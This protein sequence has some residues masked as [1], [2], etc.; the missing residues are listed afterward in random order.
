MSDCS[1]VGTSGNT[2]YRDDND[3]IR[4]DKESGLTLS[5]SDC[6]TVGTSGNT[7]YRDNT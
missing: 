5:M 7:S 1:T 4:Q 3:A 6:S 2:S